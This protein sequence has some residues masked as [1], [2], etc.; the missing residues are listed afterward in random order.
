MILQFDL[1]TMNQMKKKEINIDTN[2]KMYENYKFLHGIILLDCIDNINCNK[3]NK[4]YNKLIKWIKNKMKNNNKINN[5]YLSENKFC[6]NLLI[7]EYVMMIVVRKCGV[8]EGNVMQE[9]EMEENE[10]VKVQFSINALPFAGLI[11]CNSINQMKLVNK[12][13][14]NTMIKQCTFALE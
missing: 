10:G 7:T 5:E 12:V 8:F 14:I 1:L 9:N 3:L 13:G 4:Y 2:I 6:Y 11:F